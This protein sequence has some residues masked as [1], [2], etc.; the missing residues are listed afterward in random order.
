MERGVKSLIYNEPEYVKAAP[1]IKWTSDLT[2]PT[3]K[4]H[5]EFPW[6]NDIL[7]Q[8][9]IKI[10]PHTCLFPLSQRF[11]DS[12]VCTETHRSV[13]NWECVWHSTTLDL[14]QKN[15]SKGSFQAETVQI[16]NYF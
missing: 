1:L 12:W 11:A 14:K 2:S 10:N 16:C 5:F 15:S 6:L 8:S 4:L 9:Q 3:P 7:I 13:F